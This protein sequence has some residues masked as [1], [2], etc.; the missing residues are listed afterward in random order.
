MRNVFERFLAEQRDR[1]ALFLP[2]CLGI[3]ILLYFGRTT[4][5]S[6]A[7]A[8]LATLAPAVATG[9]LWR[10][11]AWRIP[12]LC[13]SMVAA[14]VLLGCIAALR[15]EPW[16]ALPRH[17]VQITGRVAAL[18]LLPAG[19]R[20]TLQS[21][22]LDGAPPLARALR[23]RLRDTDTSPIAP[24]DEISVRSLVQP[25][26]AP[27]TPG[28]WD[29][30]R[31][32]Y[33]DGLGGYGFAIGPATVL[34][35]ARQTALADLRARIAARIMHAL[36][37]PQGAIAATLLTGAGTAIPAADR[38]AFAD[39][40]LAHLL[41][42]A[43]L[44][45]G[46][47]MG[48]VFFLARLGLAAWEYAALA[49]PTRKI[50]ALAA[51]AAGLAYL[52]LTGAHLPI[53]RSFGMAALVTLGVLTG[54]RALSHRGLA[55]AAT[56]LMA[57]SPVSVV[58]VSFQMSFSAVLCLIAGY[59]LARPKLVRLAEGRLW[60]RP[61]LYL[62]GLVLSSLLAGTA[63]LPFAAYHFG[64]ATLYYVPANMLAVPLTAFWV[65]PCGMLALALMPFGLDQLALVPMGWG[66][67]ALAAIAH[68]V[69]TWPFATLPV[70]Q[71]PPV[72]LALV[73]AGLILLCLLRGTAR[74]VGLPLMAVGLASPFLA[75]PPDILVGA[76]A[77]LIALRLDAGHI[78]AL[79]T[80]VSAFEG[81][82]PRHLWGLD[83]APESL[84]CA[85][86]TCRITLRRQ[87]VL[88]IRDGDPEACDAALVV[89]STRLHTA[90]PDTPV[91]DHDFV[92][93]EGATTIR[94]DPMGPVIVTDLS[95]RGIRPWVIS[96]RPTLPMAP[97]E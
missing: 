57:A 71:S 8:T 89:A 93:R 58:G 46:I 40:G 47:V 62:A 75:P 2:V 72:C 60:Q 59:E 11:P 82:A 25:P 44:H 16:V 73:A 78:A 22:S 61:L 13:L 5:P 43:G 38:A 79:T 12:L 41:A 54:R 95:Q 32:A 83:A 1:L 51:L 64:R 84:P 88:V 87:A 10:W 28:G 42:V 69:A 27:D 9:L 45:I 91:I 20:L 77:R 37:V 63:S 26:A 55:L 36:P 56:L 48:L 94:L 67:A 34:Q 70:P 76:D 14:G 90:C 81:Q 3:G 35:P 39:S 21:P 19:R 50:A 92:K 52:E 66:I 74:L 96:Q 85:A 80:H 23:V 33:F 18:E 31:E 4:E 65:M 49:W 68:N 6:V 15:A 24:G 30:Q 86:A 97:T 53:L 29:T 17:A 7:W